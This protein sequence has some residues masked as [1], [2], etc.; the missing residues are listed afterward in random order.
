[1]A[2]GEALSPRMRQ[3]WRPARQTNLQ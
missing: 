1:M 3:H 2:G